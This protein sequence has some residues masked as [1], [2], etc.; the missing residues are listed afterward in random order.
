MGIIT[1]AIARQLKNCAGRINCDH[2]C[3]YVNF[4][5]IEHLPDSI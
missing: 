5:L 4:G 3:K 1:F 2:Q